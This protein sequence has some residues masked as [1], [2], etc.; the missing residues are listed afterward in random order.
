MQAGDRVVMVQED[1][2]SA[3]GKRWVIKRTGDP[4][5]IN[6]RRRFGAV[7]LIG[8]EEIDVDPDGEPPLFDAS[9]FRPAVLN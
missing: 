6:A 5:T 1:W 9:G 7:T 3:F 2:W 4:L 8:F